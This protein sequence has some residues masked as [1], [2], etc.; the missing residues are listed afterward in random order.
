MSTQARTELLAKYAG[1][2]AQDINLAFEQKL[3]VD[4]SKWLLEKVTG[5]ASQHV[6]IEGNIVGDLINKLDELHAGREAREVEEILEIQSNRDPM[7][8]WILNNVPTHKG[9]GAKVK[10]DDNGEEES[11]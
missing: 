5:K 11:K 6:N 4:A 9:V 8:E 2:Q 10:G 1:D 3:R 7:D